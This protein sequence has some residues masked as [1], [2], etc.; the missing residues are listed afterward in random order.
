MPQF[1]VFLCEKVSTIFQQAFLVSSTI[2][3]SVPVVVE[4]K[5]PGVVQTHNVQHHINFLLKI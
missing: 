3:I 1:G 2:V 5:D 4:K